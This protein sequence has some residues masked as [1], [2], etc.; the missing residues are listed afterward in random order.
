MNTIEKINNEIDLWESRKKIEE[1]PLGGNVFKA[2]IYGGTAAGLKIALQ[3]LKEEEPEDDLERL[4]NNH[5]AFVKIID[6]IVT[7][8]EDFVWCKNLTRQ[9]DQLGVKIVRYINRIIQLAE[10]EKRRKENGE[11]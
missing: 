9:I 6:E 3:M 8:Y 1:S 11:H 4:K 7:G 10:R 5:E 2:A